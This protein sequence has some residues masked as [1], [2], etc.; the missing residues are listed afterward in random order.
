MRC[1][2]RKQDVLAEKGVHRPVEVRDGFG[3]APAVPFAGVDV[4]N[5]RHAAAHQG[6]D[7]GV[8]LR[9]GTT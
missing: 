9:L 8:G 3:L 5:V 7:D 2:L 4:V 1:G 6:G